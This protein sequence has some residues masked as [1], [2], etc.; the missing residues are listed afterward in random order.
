MPVLT[1]PSMH[2]LEG[3]SLLVGVVALLTSILYFLDSY[4][5]INIA[6]EIS[7]ETLMLFFALMTL[8]SGI[9]LIASTIGMIGLK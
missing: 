1:K 4:G 7:Q 5:F 6:Y 2:I 9:V 8:I 3:A